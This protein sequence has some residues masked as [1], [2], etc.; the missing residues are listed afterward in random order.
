[1]AISELS[2]EQTTLV[3]GGFFSCSSYSSFSC[4]PSY[5]PISQSINTVVGSIL[6]AAAGGLAGIYN[7]NID[8]MNGASCSTIMQDLSSVFSYASLGAQLGSSGI[9]TGTSRLQS[10][11]ANIQNSISQGGTSK[12]FFPPM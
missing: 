2:F 8:L 1:M 12:V 5:S 4:S 7:L 10:D 11:W 9:A 6:G 3:S